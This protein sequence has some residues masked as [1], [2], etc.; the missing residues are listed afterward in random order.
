MVYAIPLKKNPKK[1]ICIALYCT[2]KPYY[3]KAGLC[4]K[5]KSRNYKCRYPLKYCYR[6]HKQNAKRRG[7]SY[8]LT[9]LQFV[10]FWS[11]LY[12]DKWEL[13]KKNVLSGSNNKI[14]NRTCDYEIDRIDPNKSYRLDNLMI[15][16]KKFNIKRQQNYRLVE[17]YDDRDNFVLPVEVVEVAQ[18]ATEVILLRIIKEKTNLDDSQLIKNNF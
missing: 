5:C 4:S 11:V 2:G 15:S 3:G 13:K 1:G 14:G 8:E 16:T 17:G 18:T 7:I 12:P 6:Y 10:Y 9:F